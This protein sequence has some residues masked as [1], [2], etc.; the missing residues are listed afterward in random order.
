M[1]QTSKR[2]Q[3]LI[4]ALAMCVSFLQIPVFA[5]DT[6]CVDNSE[7]VS[8][9]K[10]ETDGN[11]TI[12]TNCKNHP[13]NSA[14]KCYHAYTGKIA[15]VTVDKT[16]NKATVDGATTNNPTGWDEEALGKIDP[17]AVFVPATCA[18][19][20]TLTYKLKVGNGDTHKSDTI[21]VVPA[22]GIH[23]FTEADTAAKNGDYET[24]HK[25][26]EN[27]SD[28]T[29]GG[30]ATYAKI[31][32]T[33]KQAIETEKVVVKVGAKDHTARKV[34]KDGKETDEI[35][36]DYEVIVPSTCNTAGQRRKVT[37]CKDC[38]KVMNTGNIEPYDSDIPG[39]GLHQYD[40]TVN[41]DYEKI[42]GTLSE[43][44]NLNKYKYCYT[45]TGKCSVCGLADTVV[46]GTVGDFKVLNATA[47]DKKT[48][49]KPGS[50]TISFTYDA[51][52]PVKGKLDA[53]KKVTV[54]KTLDWYTDY[55][56]HDFSNPLVSDD[57]TKVPATCT[58]DGHYDMV[59]ICKVCGEKEVKATVPLPAT[60]KHTAG[61]PVKTN[62]VAAT[63]AKGGSYD[64]VTKCE[65]CGKVI[66]TEKKTTDKVKMATSYI[67][68]VKNVK[69]KKATVKVKKV[70]GYGYQIQYATN[71]S[72]KSAKYVK[73]TSTTKTLSKLAKKKY[74]VRVQ[75]YKTYNGK[76]YYSGWS[77]TKTVTIKK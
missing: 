63:P 28:C 19:A 54:E 73:T 69:G 2:L 14:A 20:G 10:V 38:G 13:K 37:V 8:T 49:C 52:A 46:M 31:C 30:D 59:K 34:I 40:Y 29:K 61:T 67:T 22:T 25:L 9:V 53:T 66:K 16:N 77:K 6:S 1:K 18:K 55:Q 42:N 35:D 43:V 12:T 68:S 17:S 11:Y 56:E 65:D 23:D 3:A 39:T 70:S 62:V 36:Y 50:I 57:E 7:E 72:F 4:L 24:Y 64:L 15:G 33:C 21:D 48:P 74:Y 58:E 75:T 26:L 5:A 51:K 44:S 41:W 60:G 27:T 71:K 76:V 32:G 47:P 45:I